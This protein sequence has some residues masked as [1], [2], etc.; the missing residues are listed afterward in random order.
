[1]LAQK[2][3]RFCHAADRK[4]YARLEPN[5]P[6][7]EEHN[8]QPVSSPP[9]QATVKAN[10][11]RPRWFFPVMVAVMLVVVGWGFGP[12]LYL[13]GLGTDNLPAN[14]QVI[15]GYAWA[16]GVALTTWFLLLAVQTTL[17]ASNRIAIHRSLGVV[18]A[19][20]ATAVIV[21]T[22]V[23]VQHAIA[24]P[25]R[26]PLPPVVFFFNVLSVVQFAVLVGCALRFRSQPAVHKRLMFL[27]SVS[28]LGAAVSRLPVASDLSP[29]V[30]PNLPLLLLAALIV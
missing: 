10:E 19:I 29:V 28:L 8:M 22:L 1:L 17:V 30:V 23:T 24:T 25:V 9:T 27:A 20:T 2:P 4:R 18:G 12:S 3:R 11:P 15:P 5:L 26:F 6:H 16:H 7:L 21:T 14:L 13:R